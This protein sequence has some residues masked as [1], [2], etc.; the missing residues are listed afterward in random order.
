MVIP[1]IATLIMN[2]FTLGESSSK[3]QNLGVLK[4]WTIGL[5]VHAYV[6]IYIIISN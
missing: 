3:I 5:F 6:V 2:K 4:V 1:C